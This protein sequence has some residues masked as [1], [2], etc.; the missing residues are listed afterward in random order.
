MYLQCAIIHTSKHFKDCTL[1]LNR[2]YGTG[3]RQWTFLTGGSDVSV[4]VT[5]LLQCLSAG[6][7]YHQDHKDHNPDVLS[8]VK[9]LVG[10]TQASY[11]FFS[12]S[13]SLHP[14]KTTRDDFI[15][16]TDISD[17]GGHC[18]TI[19][20]GGPKPSLYSYGRSRSVGAPCPSKNIHP[21]MHVRPS[22]SSAEY[23]KVFAVGTHGETLYSLSCSGGPL[24]WIRYGLLQ[25]P[26]AIVLIDDFGSEVHPDL[27]GSLVLALSA[28]FPKTQFIV[29]TTSPYVLSKARRDEVVVIKKV[30]GACVLTE[31][32]YDPRLCTSG[33]ISRSIVGVKSDIPSQEVADM[34]DRMRFLSADEMRDEDEDALVDEIRR[35]LTDLG[36]INLPKPKPMRP[37]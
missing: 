33:E 37:S 21:L 24:E 18:R 9:S 29:S 13:F 20:G 15:I 6:L 10:D 14:Y 31:P 1:F 3:E 12:T 26:E 35:K 11:V 2:H 25:T 22:Q 30:N 17:H 8:D 16:R 4:Q 23:L 5:N 34:Y 27:Q 28:A 32:E 19:I 7:V 36:F